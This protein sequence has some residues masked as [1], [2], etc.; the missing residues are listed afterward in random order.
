MLFILFG[1]LNI[2]LQV[3]SVKYQEHN[4]ILKCY[5][6]RQFLF[7][8]QYFTIKFISLNILLKNSI[9]QYILEASTYNAMHTNHS[10]RALQMEIYKTKCFGTAFCLWLCEIL[11]QNTVNI[12]DMDKLKTTVEGTCSKSITLYYRS[13]ITSLFD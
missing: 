13:L 4:Y 10:F 7:K 2:I 8:K 3:I 12:R 11:P 9:L 1:N 6:K 5:C